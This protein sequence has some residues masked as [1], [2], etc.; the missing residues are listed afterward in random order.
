MEAYMSL[1]DSLADAGKAAAAVGKAGK[2]LA[3]VA[4]LVEEAKQLK[5]SHP[6]I[7]TRLMDLAGKFKKLHPVAGAAAEKLEQTLVAKLP[8]LTS[9]CTAVANGG[10]TKSLLSK[11]GSV[12]G[13]VTK[14]AALK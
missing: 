4:P 1:L 12:E 10:D 11:I 5:T 7:Y 8:E 2:L 6:E 9:A 13:L 14:L 3:E